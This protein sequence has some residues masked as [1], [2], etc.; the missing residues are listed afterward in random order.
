MTE[1][2]KSLVEPPQ[3]FGDKQREDCEGVNGERRES[4]E[5]EVRETTIR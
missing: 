5:A 4:R 2:K 3:N 1:D